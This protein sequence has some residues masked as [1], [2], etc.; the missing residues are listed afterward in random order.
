MSSQDV[1]FVPGFIPLVH[2]VDQHALTIAMSHSQPLDCKCLLI[3]V[4]YHLLQLL[5][6]RISS[7]S[8]LSQLSPQPFH[9]IGL[10]AGLTWSELVVRNPASR[11][12]ASGPL[13]ASHL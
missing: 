4:M 9:L 1:L 13:D 2:H 7:S 3:S 12:L 11:G 6:S 10:R 5:L 8:H